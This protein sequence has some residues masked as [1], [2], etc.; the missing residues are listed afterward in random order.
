MGIKFKNQFFFSH[1]AAA[2]YSGSKYVNKP[3][4]IVGPY[5][6]VSKVAGKLN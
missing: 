5:R 4:I 6:D 1:L 2:N 3:V